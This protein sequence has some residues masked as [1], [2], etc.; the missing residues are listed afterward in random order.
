LVTRSK[1]GN[2]CLHGPHHVAQ[3]LIMYNES[4]EVLD[5]FDRDR[6]V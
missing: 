6:A 1:C 2:S 5:L 4:A 3:K